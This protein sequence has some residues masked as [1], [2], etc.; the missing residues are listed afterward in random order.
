MDQKIKL[1]A[2]KN[3]GKMTPGQNIMTVHVE[4]A[5]N[6]LGVNQSKVVLWLGNMKAETPM[7][8]GA[9]PNYDSQHRF[10]I[11]DDNDDLKVEL[12]NC[13]TN[14]QVLENTFSVRDIIQNREG[15]REGYT[16]NSEDPRGP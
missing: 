16:I 1:E 9:S 3:K 5:E 14:Q 8:P 11:D 15:W 12:I 13:Q 10:N 6:L 7:K 2:Q 4:K